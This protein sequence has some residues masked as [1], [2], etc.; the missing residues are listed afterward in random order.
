MRRPEDGLDRLLRLKGW[1]S[2]AELDHLPELTPWTDDYA[3][4]LVPLW[5]EW[6]D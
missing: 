3:S 6:T 5:L 4:V 1:R 2:G